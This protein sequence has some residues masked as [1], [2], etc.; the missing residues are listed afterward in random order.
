MKK[1]NEE[2]PSEDQIKKAAKKVRK[3]KLAFLIGE[4]SSDEEVT[5]EQ[6]LSEKLKI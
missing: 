6:K 1:E 2:K 3:G 4:D 5:F